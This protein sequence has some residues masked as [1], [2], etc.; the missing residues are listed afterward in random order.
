MGREPMVKRAPTQKKTKVPSKMCT[1]CGSIKSID[2]FYSNRAWAS[3]G[4][5]D[6]WC[7]ECVQSIAKNKE[8]MREYCWY[9]N[10]LFV[11]KMFDDCQQQAIYLLATNGE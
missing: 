1:R 7:K 5:R 8:G 11:E 9:N 3:Q 6:A 10:R 4:F 2:Q